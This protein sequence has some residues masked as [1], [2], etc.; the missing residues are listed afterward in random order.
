MKKGGGD[1]PPTSDSDERRKERER[2]RRGKRGEACNMAKA[3]Q[4]RRRRDTQE[5]DCTVETH[6]ATKART[7]GEEARER[8]TQD[9]K[10]QSQTW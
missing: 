6:V 9:G 10:L 1:A 3:S 5:R 8:E 2:V 7:D 4:E